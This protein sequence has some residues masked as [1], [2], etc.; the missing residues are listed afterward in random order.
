MIC[1][2]IDE[3]TLL[4]DEAGMLKPGT[5]CMLQRQCAFLPGG[6]HHELLDSGSAIIHRLLFHWFGRHVVRC[7][8]STLVSL[9]FVVRS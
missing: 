4:F 1:G 2:W 5:K 6:F 7:H 3:T 8:G 9:Y